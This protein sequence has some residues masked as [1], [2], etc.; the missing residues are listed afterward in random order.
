MTRATIAGAVTALQAKAL[1]AFGEAR[2]QPVLGLAAVLCV[3]DNR[4]KSRR[5]G[6][7][8]QDVIFKPR[9]F[10]CWNYDD[11]NLPMLLALAEKLTASPVGNEDI[12]LRVCFWLAGQTYSDPTHG[13]THYYAPKSVPTPPRWIREPARRTAYIGDHMF[14]ADVA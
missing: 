8:V 10:S 1:T 9:Q 4:V 12:V 6:T 14:F 11:P 7:T 2:N 5:W 13:A 3:I